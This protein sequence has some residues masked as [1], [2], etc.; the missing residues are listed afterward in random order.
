M[1]PMA[2]NTGG[3][4]PIL[5]NVWFINFTRTHTQIFQTS[6]TWIIQSKTS[7]TNFPKNGNWKHSSNIV[8]TYFWLA[9][10]YVWNEK[11]IGRFDDDF[12][13]WTTTIHC[14]I[15]HR[16]WAKLIVITF[17]SLLVFGLMWQRQNIGEII[18]QNNQ[19]IP[20][21]ESDLMLFRKI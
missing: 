18:H 4:T 13:L 17:L 16:G 8:N 15:E 6:Q 21:I 19:L 5:I 14:C 2:A 11:I 3:C 10:L 7:G 1:I 9:F 12:C 20:N